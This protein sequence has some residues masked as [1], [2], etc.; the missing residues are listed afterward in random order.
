M[1]VCKAPPVLLLVIRYN[2]PFG[3]KNNLGPP[4]IKSLFCSKHF[5]LLRSFLRAK[6]ILPGKLQCLALI[7]QKTVSLL[8]SKE[9]SPEVAVTVLI[10]P[11]SRYSPNLFDAYNVLLL[12]E[13]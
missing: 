2:L 5:Q 6:P 13:K 8:P 11:T 1:A 10:L 4:R 12:F 3:K 9:V 7:A